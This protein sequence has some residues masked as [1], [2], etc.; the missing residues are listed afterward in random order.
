V[1][2][3]S[4]LARGVDGINKAQVVTMIHPATSIENFQKCMMQINDVLG[5]AMFGVVVEVSVKPHDRLLYQV[6]FKIL[7][8]IEDD[9]LMQA[10]MAKYEKQ[11]ARD[12]SYPK[13]EDRQGGD[14]RTQSSKY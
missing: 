3:A 1:I 8:Q 4:E 12:I 10:L 9:D 5:T 7:R 13:N 11:S 14:P 6:H 2:A